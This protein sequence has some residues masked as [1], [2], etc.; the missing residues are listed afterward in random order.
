MRIIFENKTHRII[1]KQDPYYDLDDLK[2][3]SFNPEVNSDI[4]QDTLKNEELIFETLVENEGV[5]GYI[6]ERKCP[7][8]GSWEHLDSCWGFVGQYSETESRFNHYIIDEMKS[9]I[10]KGK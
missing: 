6:L 3:D 5:F 4:D 7:A 8:C 2:G 9:Q 1:E 10:E